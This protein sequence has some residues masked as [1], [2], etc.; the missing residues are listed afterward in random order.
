MIAAGFAQVMAGVA[1]FTT[2]VT[3]SLA[4]LPTPFTKYDLRRVEGNRRGPF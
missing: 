2:S 4:A 1:L 3:L